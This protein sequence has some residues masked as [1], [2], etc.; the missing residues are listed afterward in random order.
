MAHDPRV[1]GYPNHHIWLDIAITDHGV[2]RIGFLRA[3]VRIDP[4]LIKSC[5]ELVIY[6]FICVSM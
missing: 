2:D 5:N 3:H 4:L 1:T 6:F